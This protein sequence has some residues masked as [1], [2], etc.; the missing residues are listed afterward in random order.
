MAWPRHRLIDS[1]TETLL[2]K[3]GLVNS[4]AREDKFMKEWRGDVGIVVG[5]ATVLNPHFERAKWSISLVRKF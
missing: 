5:P 4:Q 2:K 1:E 3:S